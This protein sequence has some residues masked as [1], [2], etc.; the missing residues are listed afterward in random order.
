MSHRITGKLGLARSV[1]ALID[2]YEASTED[3]QGGS[4][5]RFDA[6]SGQ[7]SVRNAAGEEL[8][9]TCTKPSG[10]K[11]LLRGP[12][13]QEV[14]GFAI[15]KGSF[16]P[17]KYVHLRGERLRA[18]LMLEGRKRT[19]GN[20]FLRIDHRDFHSHVTYECEP[21]LE[22]PSLVLAFILFNVV[23]CVPS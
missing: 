4:V 20:A 3:E 5:V 9:R 10:E 13:R 23:N 17:H 19:F 1:L 7:F 16:N 14:E 15:E 22:L 8:A 21:E 2:I 12:E 6:R 18:V 11:V